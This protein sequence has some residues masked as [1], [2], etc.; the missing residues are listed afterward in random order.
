MTKRTL[1]F[2][3]RR[4]ITATTLVEVL[5]V[6]VVFLVGILAIAQIFP[7]GLKILTRTRNTSMAYTLGRS[8]LETLKSRPD[9]LPEAI[10][11]VSYSLT[12][13][14]YLPSVNYDRLPNEYSPVS[15]QISNTGIAA[16]TGR[17][18]Q[19]GSGSNV[20]R[21]VIGESH[22]IPAPRSMSP[23]ASASAPIGSLV[24]LEFGPI[25]HAG[26]I[27]QVNGNAPAQSTLQVYGRDMYR[28]E[29][30]ADLAA[31]GVEGLREY[32]Y[33]TANL[34]AANA[35]IALPA[36]KT[37]LPA[38]ITNFF[39][40]SMVVTVN[41]GGN[42]IRRNIV[43]YQ[44]PV[45]PNAQGQV[46]APFSSMLG[47]LQ[48]GDGILSI[49]PNS[50]RVAQL[51]KPIASTIPFDDND[52]F[53]F[54]L[55]N[56]RIGHLLINPVLFNRF[57]ERSGSARESYVARID[58]DVRDWR[59]LH[60][61][62]RISESLPA[63]YPK[64]IKLSINSLKTNSIASSDG[65]R[66]PSHAD[67]L[68][69]DVPNSGMEDVYVADNNAFAGANTVNADNLLII[70]TETGSQFAES[71]NGAPSFKIDKSRGVLTILDADGVAGNGLTQALLTPMGTQVLTNVSGRSI[72]VFY[73]TKDEWAIQVARNAAH[74]APAFGD[75]GVG[76]FYVGGTDPAQQGTSTRLYFPRMDNGRK[77]S[78][79]RVRWVD[80][81]GNEN[82]LE[83]S[84]FQIKFQTGA[85][86]HVRA[87]GSPST[88][89]LPSIDI[90][91]VVPNAVSIAME[92]GSPS[93]MAY[94]VRDVRGVSML[95]RVFFNNSA[96]NLNATPALNLTQNFN[97]W[98][99]EWNVTSKET[100]LHR[101]ESIR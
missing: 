45:P 80:A 2:S 39:R 21:R 34:Q 31:T 37:L 77:V 47:L 42:F 72:R 88:L 40:I 91:E 81:G 10:V 41:N 43:G 92:T 7:G 100:Y 56:G 54:K 68:T 44:Y 22:R 85:D 17:A 83:G 96:F 35:S 4:S 8:Q 3:S 55:V 19:L 52:P 15:T 58:Y 57:E 9:S 94:A 64:V 75:P 70:D 90:R 73:M 66:N 48:P 38:P 51:Y 5:V 20:A 33:A 24:A 28:R 71:Y 98:A 53:T 27:P 6:I 95:A 74:Y 16:E 32:E 86:N 101:G 99:R 76:Q 36:N 29:G 59:I 65:L 1:A 87:S 49:E 61:D 60:E 79:G 97:I 12:G 18:W 89:P 46:T 30:S 11:P 69:S 14:V 84:E 67:T 23:D 25:D 26:G 78:I 63:N 62:F 50:V 82:V 93:S 13:G